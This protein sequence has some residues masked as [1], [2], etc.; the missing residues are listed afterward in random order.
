M[1]EQETNTK[2]RVRNRELR[3]IYYFDLVG[4]F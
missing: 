4:P 3:I 2:A 1:L